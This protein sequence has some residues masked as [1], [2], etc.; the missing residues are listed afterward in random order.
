MTKNDFIKSITFKEPQLQAYYH[1]LPEEVFQDTE[2]Y[3]HLKLL[4]VL[5]EP[6]FLVWGVEPYFLPNAKALK[7]DGLIE[8]FSKLKAFPANQ[9]QILLLENRVFTFEFHPIDEQQPH[10]QKGV[11]YV[12][13]ES[14]T[15]QRDAQILEKLPV[16]ACIFSTK[17]L[18]V[19]AANDIMLSYWDV[20]KNVIGKPLQQILPILHDQ[21]FIALL[22]NIFRTG[23]I[24]T[25]TQ[26]PAR[27]LRN[28]ME[29]TLYFDFTYVPLKDDNGN[30]YAILSTATDVT[31]RVHLN[32]KVKAEQQQFLDLFEN[33]AVAVAVLDKNLVFEKANPFYLSLVN[34]TAEEIIDRPLLDAIPE[35]KGQGFDELLLDVIASGKPYAAKSE[36]AEITKN[37]A[38]Q[39]IYVDFTFQPLV[40]ETGEIEGVFV[41]VTDVTQSVIVD[42]D[43]K[44]KEATLQSI[45]ENAAAG[46]SLFVGRDLVIELPNKKIVELLGKGPD[47]A[48]KKLTEVMPELLTENQ[49]II[50]ILHGVFDSGIPYSTQDSMVKIVHDGVLLEK[51]YNFT[52][53]PLFDENKNVYAVLQVAIEVTDSVLARKKIVEAQAALEQAVDLAQLATWQYDL[54]SSTLIGN[55]RFTDWFKNVDALDAEYL[56]FQK[57]L[58][59]IATHPEELQGKTDFRDERVKIEPQTGKKR[60][61]V[62]AVKISYDDEQ[63]PEYISGT[64]QDVTVLRQKEEELEKLVAKR[65]KQLEVVNSTLEQTNHSLEQSNKALAQFAYVASHDLQEPL[66]KITTFVKMLASHLTEKDSRTET[67]IE[68]IINSSE[69][70][71]NLIRD[72][73]SYSQLSNGETKFVQVDLNTVISE[74]LADFDLVIEQKNAVV[75]VTDLPTVSGIKIQL[76]QLFGNVISNSLKYC[77]D[78]RSPRIDISYTAVTGDQVTDLNLRADLNYYQFTIRDN[79]IGFSQE[80]AEQIFNIFQ[81]LHGKLEYSGTGIGLAMCRKICENHSGAIRSSGTEGIGATFDIYLP[82]LQS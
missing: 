58:E 36:R 9:S 10:F 40:L 54:K 55:R 70:M 30:V 67:Y 78:S 31:A 21:P 56:E 47:V 37:G 3:F 82:A 15:D 66:R 52:Y 81:R 18:I 8:H 49:S 50:G 7:Y 68:R 43:N 27:L 59:N 6:V 25:S 12:K 33:A 69:R 41:I 73:L 14:S 62:S 4:L 46:I 75:H 77:H 64:S 57:F 48:G 38:L 17:E 63:K 71:S 13:E 61:I 24:H 11:L 65:T 79:G 23:E 32:R 20:D 53:T 34:R 22:Q 16:A 26:A 42:A 74:I 80:Y 1:N 72:I 28:G 51:Y 60:I 29:Q 5:P 2:L 19:T 44:S 35:I 39:T 45:L 76:S